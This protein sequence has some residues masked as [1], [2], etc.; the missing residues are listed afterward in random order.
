MDE[1]LESALVFLRQR[2]EEDV[3]IETIFGEVLDMEL[4]RKGDFEARALPSLVTTTF[5]NLN[6]DKNQH[7]NTLPLFQN[8]IQHYDQ[9]S[10]AQISPN[11]GG[12][13]IAKG[14]SFA[15]LVGTPLDGWRNPP[16]I[17]E[18]FAFGFTIQ[19]PQLNYP[20][21]EHE[22]IELYS[23]LHGESF[24]QQANSEF[25]KKTAGDVILHHS[26]VPHA[27]ETKSDYLVTFYAWS[28][29]L[30]FQPTMSPNS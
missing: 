10:W 6:L 9:L 12:E 7:P 26:F 5:S 14:F 8:L 15:S 24:W 16:F 20:P 13:A 3:G 23:I 1:L 18:D 27:T 29:N 2:C 17:A 4:V 19:A 28:G 30:N 21:H 11:Y 25:E 22:P